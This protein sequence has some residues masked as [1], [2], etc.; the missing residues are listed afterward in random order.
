MPTAAKALLF[1]AVIGILGIIASLLPLVLDVEAHLGL[2]LLFWLRGPRPAPPEVALVTIERES[3]DYFH[4]RNE[5]ALWPRALHARAVQELSARGARVIVFDIA[6][7]KPQHPEQDRLLAQAL[8]EAGNVVLLQLLRKDIQ[9]LQGPREQSGL[10]IQIERQQPLLPEVARAA[11]G[12]A[13]FL[14]PK[15][16][17][18][19]D[20][21]WFFK[22]SAGDIPTLPTVAF[23]AYALA[24]HA[25]L[26][27]LLQ[28]AGTGHDAPSPQMIAELGASRN[29]SDVAHRLRY[30]LRTH[31]AFA[32]RLFERLKDQQ[33]FATP[34][35]R[36]VLSSLLQLYVGEG[37][38]YLD[39]Y[40]P[41]QSILS[42]PYHHLLDSALAGNNGVA[43]M[44]FSGKVVFVGFAEQSQ[45]E[46]KDGFYTVFSGADGVDISG[47]EIA[48][49]AFANILEGRRVQ[50][51]KGLT[52][53]SLLGAFGIVTGALL[54]ALPTVFI[55]FAATGIALAYVTSAY[56]AFLLDGTWLP[57]AVPL[58]LQLPLALLGAL[59][60]RY[61][62]A[63]HQYQKAQVTFGHYVPQ[64]IVGTLIRDHATPANCRRFVYGACL[65]TDAE[66]YTRLSETLS[67]DQLRRFLNRYYQTL[68]DPVSRH[69]GFISDVVGD[70]MLAIWAGTIPDK[71]LRQS[72]CCT[73]LDILHELNRFRLR[74]GQ[75]ALPT[76]FGL[77]AGVMVLGN[78][79]A[80]D[81]FE[82][83][84]VGDVVNTTHRLEQLNKVL[85]T[86][87]LASAEIL[88]GLDGVVARALGSFQ[89]AGKRHAFLVYELMGFTNT[90][91]LETE[92]LYQ[93]FN[94]A[95]EA[96]RAQRFAEAQRILQQLLALYPDDGPSHFYVGLCQRLQR[97]PPQLGWDGVIEAREQNPWM[98]FGSQRVPRS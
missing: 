86:R 47:V 69:G 44:S 35:A 9:H 30:L 14:L 76:R 50:P 51:L 25:D 28:E 1:G 6:F 77:H 21:C 56:R 11:W 85:G 58:L 55:P 5:P 13:P 65:A 10:Q 72:A 98:N 19:V 23:Q 16:P 83:R 22:G 52:Y 18:R 66:Q 95:M 36:R 61:A 27:R 91:D 40:G 84:A 49:T 15:V 24:F 97:E 53:V 57:F 48:A 17:V 79:G 63:Q 3:A 96:F 38:Q 43:P 31:D 39:F 46:Q 67:P 8:Q 20:E 29:P 68:F 62:Q 74:P 45:A 88:K 54:L 81:H 4:L 41:P 82:Y 80:G 33:H 64:G 26:L 94:V 71:K 59:L 92:P 60:W 90:I 73:A 32:Q 87:I 2:K 7:E 12:M 37:G 78:V 42:V 75:A 89:L 34:A 70:A 93:Q